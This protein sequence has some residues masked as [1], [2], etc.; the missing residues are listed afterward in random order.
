MPSPRYSQYLK[1]VFIFLILLI[2]VYP[3][4][5]SEDI[6]QLSELTVP[7]SVYILDDRDGIYS[8]E[9]SKEE[10]VSI[11]QKVN[12]IWSQAAI[13]INVRYTDRTELPHEIIKAFVEGNY[14][15]FLNGINRKFNL[16]NHSIINA[17]YSKRIGGPN[18]RALTR[19]GFFL[20]TDTP[21]VHDQRVT[22]HEIGHLL[23]LGHE[24]YNRKRLMY[25]GTNGIQ[26]T[27]KEINTARKNAAAILKSSK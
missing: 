4:V 16:Q 24:L 2:A 10:I 7:L 21:F 11:F 5:Y 3:D 27:T 19:Y 15:P 25:S 20:V 18:G 12:E 6:D 1:P 23:G 22:S 26:L 14:K 9:R 8:S 13:K 17:F